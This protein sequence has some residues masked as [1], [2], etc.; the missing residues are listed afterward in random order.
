M[1][2]NEEKKLSFFFFYY[3][4][5]SNRINRLLCMT[6]QRQRTEK[7]DVVG[8]TFYTKEEYFTSVILYVGHIDTRKILSTRKKHEYLKYLFFFLC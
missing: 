6:S 5:V 1:S 3:L 2:I 4:L 8:K 7:A